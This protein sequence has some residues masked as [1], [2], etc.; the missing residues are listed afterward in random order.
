V[1]LARQDHARLAQRTGI[2]A[3]V[4][5]STRP[6]AWLPVIED[7]VQAHF[8]RPPSLS[9]LATV[10][11]RS[12]SQIVRAFRRWRGISLGSFARRLRAEHARRALLE[13]NASLSEISLEAGYSDQSHMTREL[14][15]YLGCTPGR[16]RRARR[17]KGRSP[18]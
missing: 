13:T 11:D 6:P 5:E 8:R 16:L 12:P 15:L 3:V 17:K 9:E 2:E 14:S 1:V 18:F 4:A 7:V 10:V